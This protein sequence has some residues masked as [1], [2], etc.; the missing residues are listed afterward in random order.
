MTSSFGSTPSAPASLRIVAAWA[1]PEPCSRLYTVFR[2]TPASLASSRILST[3]SRRS[4]FSLSTFTSTPGTVTVMGT[5]YHE[6]RQGKSRLGR[7]LAQLG[8]YWY[9]RAVNKAP[10]NSHQEDSGAVAT[11][12]RNVTEA[13]TNV[14]QASDAT[15]Q[16]LESLDTAERLDVIN[17]S[18]AVAH[19]TQCSAGLAG[20]VLDQLGISKSEFGIFLT[21]A[22]V[23]KVNRLYHTALEYDTDKR[24]G[25]ALS[26]CKKVAPEKVAEYGE[27]EIAA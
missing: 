25:V 10:A 9:N 7:Q 26:W 17:D 21:H 13:K 1:L 24:A 8:Q 20:W 6:L 15:W 11:K 27:P 18:E 23:T 16:Y 22:P 14:V 3:F 19:E 2:F 5:E 4:A 12:G